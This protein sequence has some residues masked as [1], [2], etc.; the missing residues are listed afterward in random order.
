MDKTI[1]VADDSPEMTEVLTMTL[2]LCNYRVEVARN[3]VEAFEKIVRQKPALL[4]LDIMMPKKNGYQLCRELKEN[5][6]YEDIPIIMLTA[7]RQPEDEYWAR[8]CGADEFLT[9]PFS[10]QALEEIVRRYM[11]GKRSS[12]EYFAHPKL[13]KGSFVNR[14]I[15]DRKK[16]N[17]SF[18]VCSFFFDE[19]PLEIFRQKYGEME[20]QEI[21]AK[22]SDILKDI[23]SGLLRGKPLLGY[24]GNNVFLFVLS[25]P[26]DK[27]LLV[28]RR[29]C[30]N[31][32]R[33][34]QKA[35][36]EEDQRRGFVLCSRP[37]VEKEEQMP[38]LELQMVQ[39]YFP[40][41]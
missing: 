20:L 18:G 6:D 5:P 39:T 19:Q 34:L 11:E 4:I 22:T 30:F 36:D 1:L 12:I 10:S 14:D 27:L 37:Q 7:K 40:G 26:Q 15:A 2:E 33:M 16:A 21:L 28:A 38:L 29:I 24:Q 25:S 41:D 23:T 17:E 35:Y 13:P 31:V 32:N 9:K 3:G 8:D